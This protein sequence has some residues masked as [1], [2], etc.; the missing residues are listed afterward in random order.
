MIERYGSEIKLTKKEQR[1]LEQSKQA[2]PVII[3]DLEPASRANQLR[4][5]PPS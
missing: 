1:R 3:D 2:K 5:S 4:S